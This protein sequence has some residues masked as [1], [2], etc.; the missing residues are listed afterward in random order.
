LF[1]RCRGAAHALG[2][3]IS[4]WLTAF[5]PP[6]EPDSSQLARALCACWPL[7][8]KTGWSVTPRANHPP[9]EVRSRISIQCH[10][11]PFVVHLMGRFLSPLLTTF[12]CSLQH[13]IGVHPRPSLPPISIP[14]V[15]SQSRRPFQATGHAIKLASFGRPLGRDPPPPPLAVCSPAQRPLGPTR[16]KP[17]LG[18]PALVRVFPCAFLALLFTNTHVLCPLGYTLFLWATNRPLVP[19]ALPSLRERDP[20]FVQLDL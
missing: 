3:P 7:T 16:T 6:G 15:L 19:L 1:A 18:P 9:M 2:P 5:W 8:L 11:V 20:A 10:H 14:H 12:L 4:S 13:P 17:S